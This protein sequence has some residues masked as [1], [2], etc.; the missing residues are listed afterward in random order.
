MTV[1][2]KPIKKSKG[3]T[4]PNPKSQRTT[5]PDFKPKYVIKGARP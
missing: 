4:K 1:R 3:L 5:N 2:R